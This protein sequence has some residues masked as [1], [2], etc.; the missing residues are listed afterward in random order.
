MHQHSKISESNIYSRGLD[1]TPSL[2]SSFT[3]SIFNLS[4]TAS[5]LFSDL[6]EN[7]PFNLSKN[8]LLII[9]PL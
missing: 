7:K 4:L 8:L 9:L 1:N 5:L 6:V 2:N 3:S